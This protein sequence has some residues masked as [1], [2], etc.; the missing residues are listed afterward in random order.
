ML[1]CWGYWTCLDAAGAVYV[2]KRRTFADIII[3]LESGPQ[4]TG[5]IYP[6]T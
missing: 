5:I 6:M 3:A 2:A 1:I 4:N